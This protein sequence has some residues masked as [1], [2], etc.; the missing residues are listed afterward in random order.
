MDSVFGDAANIAAEDER[1]RR[2]E[3]CLESSDTPSLARRLPVGSGTRDTG[4]NEAV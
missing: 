1:R 3:R 4:C 2:I